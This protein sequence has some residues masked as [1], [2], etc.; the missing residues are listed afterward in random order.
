VPVEGFTQPQPE[1]LDFEQVAS[2]GLAAGF[3]DENGL[4]SADIVS[5][6]GP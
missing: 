4:A 3:A 5:P 6:L 2:L 1:N